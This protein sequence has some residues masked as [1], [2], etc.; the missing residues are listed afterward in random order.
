M[1]PKRL[2][3]TVT[4]IVRRGCQ[5]VTSVRPS[6]GRGSRRR[7]IQPQ[8]FVCA[9]PSRDPVEDLHQRPRTGGICSPGTPAAATPFVTTSRTHFPICP[10]DS[11][12]PAPPGAIV[13]HLPSSSPALPAHQRSSCR[14][15]GYSWS[16]AR[17]GR[18]GLPRLADQILAAVPRLGSVPLCATRDRGEV[19]LHPNTKP[20][21]PDVAPPSLVRGPTQVFRTKL[22]AAPSCPMISARSPRPA[23]N[24]DTRSAPSKSP[25]HTSHQATSLSGVQPR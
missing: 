19:V 21:H 12:Q 18:S 3:R 24:A 6:P 10:A 1:L 8:H 9:R 11:S 22:L 20:V 16:L 13:S 5:S 17:R 7:S 2:A 14:Y 15:A 25:S 4:P 23:R